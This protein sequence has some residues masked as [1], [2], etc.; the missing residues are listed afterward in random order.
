M[1]VEVQREGNGD[2]SFKCPSCGLPRIMAYE[3]PNGILRFGSSAEVDKICGDH[4]RDLCLLKQKL[5]P[6]FN[7]VEYSCT[8]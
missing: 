4:P 7:P 2:I 6:F 5:S 1:I 3:H 8:D